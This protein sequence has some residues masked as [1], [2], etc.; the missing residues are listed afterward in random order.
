[1]STRNL[2]A[3]LA[4]AVVAWTCHA[5]AGDL[6]PASREAYSRPSAIPFPA[7]N[8]Y[9]P[10]KAALGKALFF[11][12]RLSGAENMTCSSC[13]NPSFGWQTRN[14]TAVG[15][16]NTHLPRRAPTI[17]DTAWIHAF[18]WDG[19]APSA[20]AQAKSP[21]QNPYEMNLPLD[22]A[23]ARLAAI[24][25]YKARFERIFPG[26]GVTADTLVGALATYERTVVSSYAPFDA[27]IEGD[28]A[29]VPDAA[30]RGFTLFTT[31]A[32]CSGCHTGW[33]FTD[34][35][36][37]D[38]GT[39]E[40]DLGRGVVD[41]SNPYAPFAFKTPSLRDVAQR[42]PYMHDGQYDTLEEV[43]AHYVGGGIDRPSRSP[44]MR[45]VPL[46]AEDVADLVA[47]LDTLTGS[48]QVVTLP[49]LPN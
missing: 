24:P 41:P 49:V 17:L 19:R 22:Q 32:R 6:S 21:I 3:S 46:T 4:I 40:G 7:D 1:M 45:P 25:E 31:T 11:E 15:S 5:S 18:F 14:K 16:Q 34:N 33:N 36:F 43:V 44:M 23:V 27:W 26:Q 8:P 42:S 28:E 38:I 10:D 9:T 20:E 12:P 37:H 35:A 13:H 2:G 30:K 48:K 47:F 29:A 39:S